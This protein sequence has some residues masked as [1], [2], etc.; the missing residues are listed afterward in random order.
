MTKN[1]KKDWFNGTIGTIIKFN[2][3]SITVKIGN[4]N[5]YVTK[6][7]WDR[8]SYKYNKNS[9]KIEEEVLGTFEQYPMRLGWAV[10]I[11]KSQGLTLN[12][13]YIDLG[14]S[15]FASGQ[16]YVALSRCR[17]LEG[18]K[19]ARPLRKSD[20]IINPMIEEFYEEFFLQN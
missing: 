15:A 5:Y 20:I 14:R 16:T 4:S 8:I 7:T 6:A 12:N 10:T 13:V 19:M 11:H 9:K 3:N 2:E 1:N 18:I 17:T